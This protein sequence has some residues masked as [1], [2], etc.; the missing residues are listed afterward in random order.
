MRPRDSARRRAGRGAGRDKRA[1]V[2]GIGEAR[3]RGT[4]PPDFPGDQTAPCPR[5]HERAR[6]HSPLVHQTRVGLDQEVGQV[7]ACQVLH[8]FARGGLHLGRR[9]PAGRRRAVGQQAAGPRLAALACGGRRRRGPVATG[10]DLGHICGNFGHREPADGGRPEGAGQGCGCPAS[11]SRAGAGALRRPEPRQGDQGQGRAGSGRGP[12]LW[13]LFCRQA[14]SNP[15]ASS[16]ASSRRARSGSLGASSLWGH[17]VRAVPVAPPAPA[18]PVPCPLHPPEEGHLVAVQ[19]GAEPQRRVVPEWRHDE[20]EGQPQAHEEGGQHDLQDQPSAAR[21]AHAPGSPDPPCPP[22]YTTP[23]SQC[24]RSQ[25][26]V[27]GGEYTQ[28]QAAG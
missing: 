25:A 11:G 28:A 8:G 27:Q 13:E 7:P 17:M 1:S 14:A 6:P 20:A 26:G 18:P 16:S 21:P 9:G 19:A 5:T 2:A 15:A 12:H 24:K 23:G 3:G 4:A 10:Q 22:L